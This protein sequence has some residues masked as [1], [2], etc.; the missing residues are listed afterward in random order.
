MVGGVAGR[1]HGGLAGCDGGVRGE[2]FRR[3]HSRGARWDAPGVVESLGGIFWVCCSNTQ[4]Y[5][6]GYIFWGILWGARKEAEL[7]SNDHT[8][9]KEQREIPISAQN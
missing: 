8:P 1:P 9:R 2:E 4:Q 3:S 5:I 6:A 7:K